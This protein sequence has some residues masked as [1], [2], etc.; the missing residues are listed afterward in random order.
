MALREAFFVVQIKDAVAL[1]YSGASMSASAFLLSVSNDSDMLRV[2]CN[3]LLLRDYCIPLI[4]GP[5][6]YVLLS[7]LL[8][9]SL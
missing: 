3:D 9:P 8:S 5:C 6:Q 1:V 7:T 2:Q 4:A